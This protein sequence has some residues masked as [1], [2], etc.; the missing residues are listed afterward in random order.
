MFKVVRLKKKLAIFITLTMFLTAVIICGGSISYSTFSSNAKSG[1]PVPII[2]YHSICH[3]KSGDYIVTPEMFKQDMQFLKEN[4]YTTIFTTDLVSYVYDDVPLPQKPVVVTLDDG[5]L[6]N[7]T[8]AL[9]IIQELNIKVVIS[10]VGSYSEQFSLKPDRNEYYAH[11]TWDDINELT[12]SGLVEIGNHT[13]DM[14]KLDARRGCM[15]SPGES[16]QSYQSALK[17]NL[18]KTQELLSSNCGIKPECFA[19]PY[20]FVSDDSYDVLKALGFKSAL[21]C[22]EKIN[23]ITKD[24]DELYKLCRFNRSGNYTTNDFMKKISE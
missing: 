16:T 14:H 8:N 23:Y 7:L 20:G 12:A 24:K 11:L 17:D 10:I 18:Q 13:Y 19:Y 2:M 4:G 9:P 6:N 22:S 1:I 21:T 3:N 15:K 5:F